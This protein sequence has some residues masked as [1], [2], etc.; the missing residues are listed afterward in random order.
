MRTTTRSTGDRVKYK[1]IYVAGPIT[2]GDTHIN[3]RNGMLAGLE[4]IKRGFVPFVPHLDYGM[5]FIDPDTMHYE[6]MLAQDFAW[7]ER[8]DALLRLPGDSSG[9]DREV[10]HALEH[11]LIVVNHIDY[12][13]EANAHGA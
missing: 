3:V 11:G 9:A 7:I 1:Y 10:K 13:E 2:K 12:L 6:N 5:R 4:L 8:C